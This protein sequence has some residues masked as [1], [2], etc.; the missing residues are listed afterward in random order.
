M[1]EIGIDEVGRGAWAGPLV[2]AAVAIP[3]SFR[4]PGEVVIRDSKALS[5]AQR[6]R[7]SVYIKRNFLCTFAIVSRE[8][9]DRVGVHN[10]NKL[11][12]LRVAKRAILKAQR[13]GYISNA[14][15]AHLR[16]D[17][18][19]IVYLPYN[20]SYYI[21]GESLYR[22]IAAASIV[23]KVYRDRLM[24]RLAKKLPGYGFEVHKGYGTRVHGEQIRHLGVSKEH[25]LSYKPIKNFVTNM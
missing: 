24:T 4:I 16:I 18:R 2:A 20:Y 15:Q 5:H 19:T 22:S 11:A 9:I 17:G 8:T 6:V 3:F 14:Y 13:R 25:R 12:F 21:K 1:I 7:S 23:A 10:A